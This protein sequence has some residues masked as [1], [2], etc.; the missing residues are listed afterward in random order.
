MDPAP[1]DEWYETLTGRL[2]LRE[3]GIIESRSKYG[4]VETL[5][6][7]KQNLVAI[8]TLSRGQLPRRLLLDFAGLLSMKA[9]AREFWTENPNVALAVDKLAILISSH[10]SQVLG[11][12]LIGLTRPA[13]PVRLFTDEA[14]ALAWLHK[15]PIAE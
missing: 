7:A 5:E 4:T 11:N 12:V 14:Q 2:R 10:I 6:S 1:Q 13:M 8:Q 3:D 9:E 15:R